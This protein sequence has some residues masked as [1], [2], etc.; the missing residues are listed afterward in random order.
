MQQMWGVRIA[1]GG[2][3]LALLGAGCGGENAGTTAPAASGPATTSTG[4]PTGAPATTPGSDRGPISAAAQPLCRAAELSARLSQ[5]EPAAGN[6]YAELL[7]TNTG[8][9]SCRTYGYV[10]LQ[11]HDRAGRPL[12]TRV[13]REPEPGPVSLVL[14]PGRSAWTRLHWGAVPGQAESQTGPCEPE[15]ASLVVTPPDDTAHLRVPWTFGPV[16]EHGQMW[17]TPLLPGTGAPSRTP[18]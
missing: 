16:C 14:A 18:G 8:H 9:A 10:G 13:D 2:V 5:V 12:P 17:V 15:P 4:T 1:V 11:L 7:L 3:A 6:R